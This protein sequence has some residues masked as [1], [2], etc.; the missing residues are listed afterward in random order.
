MS[1]K[2]S[3]RPVCG[4][5]DRMQSAFQKIVVALF[6]RLDLRG[7]P[8]HVSTI[9]HP[10]E[11]AAHV[12]ARRERLTTAP[13]LCFVVLASACLEDTVVECGDGRV[14]PAHM[15]CDARHHGC[16]LPEQLVIGKV[17]GLMRNYN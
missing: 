9:S 4:I 16:V 12:S 3:E 11:R 7:R 6:G 8:G 10:I 15:A 2:F 14:C 17:I 1:A 5:P 13:F